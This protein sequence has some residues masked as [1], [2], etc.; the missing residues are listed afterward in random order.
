MHRFGALRFP[1]SI[2]SLLVEWLPLVTSLCRILVSP[3]KT[4][5]SVPRL[6][7]QAAVCIPFDFCCSLAEI[8]AA[9]A[10]KFSIAAFNDT[11]HCEG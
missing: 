10:L 3:G 5:E 6:V 11:G 9:N 1:H 4:L 7:R 8:R 2:Q